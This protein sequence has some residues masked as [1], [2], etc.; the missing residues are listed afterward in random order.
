M[1]Q[2]AIFV[3]DGVM[4]LISP[5][6]EALA[7]GLTLKVIAEQATPDYSPFWFIDS[8]DVPDTSEGVSWESLEVDETV[9]PDGYGGGLAP[10]VEEEETNDE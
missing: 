6:P 5:S 1:S 8:S 10:A 3:R 9:T 4:A 7:K 2:V